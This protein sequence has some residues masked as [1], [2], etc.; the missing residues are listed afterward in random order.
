M[1]IRPVL[2]SSI[3]L[4]QLRHRIPRI[5][6]KRK[7]QLRTKTPTHKRTPS[8]RKSLKSTQHAPFFRKRPTVAERNTNQKTKHVCHPTVGLRLF[9][10]LFRCLCYGN[11]ER[12][13]RRPQ[14]S[15][16]SICSLVERRKRD[17]NRRPNRHAHKVE[18]LI[19]QWNF[20]VL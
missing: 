20:L 16:S 19:Q 18:K 13:D 11:M 3:H 2:S 4:Q 7:A 8:L 14:R 1:E 6:K 12:L 15:P 17:S 9:A 10:D 5:H